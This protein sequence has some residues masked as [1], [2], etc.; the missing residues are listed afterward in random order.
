IAGCDWFKFDSA[1]GFGDLFNP[2]YLIPI[3]IDEFTEA[4]R[5]TA[6]IHWT[7]E[8]DLFAVRSAVDIDVSIIAFG[9]RLDQKIVRSGIAETEVF[10][11]RI[12][13]CIKTVTE[14]FI[15]ENVEAMRR[16][17]EDL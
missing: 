1:V 9:I 11:S 15:I 8:F 14:F 7:E 3:G 13:G 2:R 6:G 16:A 17:F 4:F 5:H 10:V 12:D